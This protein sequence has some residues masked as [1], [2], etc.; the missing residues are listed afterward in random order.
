VVLY[1]QIFLQGFLL[2][3]CELDSAEHSAVYDSCFQQTIS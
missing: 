3:K 2:V 1:R